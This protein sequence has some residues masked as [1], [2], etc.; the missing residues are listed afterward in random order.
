MK[1]SND[2]AAWLRSAPRPARAR[3]SEFA[4]RHQISAVTLRTNL[5]K[6]QTSWHVLWQAEIRRRMLSAVRDDVPARVL[7]EELGYAEEQSLFR[8]FKQLTGKTYG[9]ARAEAR[10]ELAA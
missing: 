9:A 6:E 2:V 5:R 8:A 4:E 10:E 3:S 7:A 1:W